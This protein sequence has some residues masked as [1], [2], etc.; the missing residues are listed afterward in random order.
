M[1]GSVAAI[2]PGRW[3]FGQKNVESQHRASV[4]LWSVPAKVSTCWDDDG[5]LDHW[6]IGSIQS[7][8]APDKSGLPPHSKSVARSAGLVGVFI[9]S[10]GLLAA[11]A[12]TQALC[13]RALPALSRRT[14]L[15]S[16]LP[17]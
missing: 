12:A 17:F 16:S 4:Q 5:A 2:M 15:G 6:I 1:G 8:V 13:C 10:W 3:S 11:L 14:R 7:G 9:P